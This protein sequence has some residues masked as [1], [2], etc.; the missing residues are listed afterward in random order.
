MKPEIASIPAKDAP[1]F[2]YSNTPR[3]SPLEAKWRSQNDTFPAMPKSLPKPRL[4]ARLFFFILADAFGGFCLALGSSWFI[5]GK[6]LILSDIPASL[7]EA[8]AAIAGGVAVMSW[9][10]VKL[11][12][13][14]R[15]TEE[16]DQ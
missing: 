13:A 9:A 16:Q 14:L 8:V 4:S 11:L 1:S 2:D 15:T 6:G 3:K 10:M 5:G 7:A 12:R